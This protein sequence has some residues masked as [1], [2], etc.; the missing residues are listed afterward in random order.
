MMYENLGRMLGHNQTLKIRCDACARQVEW[1]R[2]RAF[3]KLGATATPFEIRRRMQCL[4]CEG[5]RV[6]VWI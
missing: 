2:A 3:Q 1:P 6:T 5:R 4:A